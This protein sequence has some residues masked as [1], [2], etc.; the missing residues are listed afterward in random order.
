M[1]GGHDQWGVGEPAGLVSQEPQGIS[2]KPR[3]GG[4]RSP[5]QCD[6]L[7][8]VADGDKSLQLVSEDEKHIRV[9]GRKKELELRRQ[10]DIWGQLWRSF[11]VKLG[12]EI[13]KWL[14]GWVS[15]KTKKHSLHHF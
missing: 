4:L 7:E 9:G 1:T 15:M 11:A 10:N 2:Q 14:L 6:D 3:R 12:R 8:E 13:V 5:T